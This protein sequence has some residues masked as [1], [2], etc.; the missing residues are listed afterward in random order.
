M[1]LAGPG[2]TDIRIDRNGQPMPDNNGDCILVTGTACWMQDIW[3]ELLTDE[4]ELLHEDAEDREAY[5]YGLSEYLNAEFDE[6]LQGELLQQITDK[7]TK[8]D[9][10]DEASIGIGFTGPDAMD[11]QW[12]VHLEFRETGSGTT[13]DVDIYTD[14]TEVYVT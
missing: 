4:G 9:Y 7:L 13:M 2:D 3:L 5:G 11:G 8:R 1:R 12:A 10:I 6:E 14:G